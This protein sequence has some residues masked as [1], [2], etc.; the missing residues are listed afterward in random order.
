MPWAQYSVPHR[1]GMAVNV[2]LE[3]RPSEGINGADSHPWLHKEFKVSLRYLQ[4][5]LPERKGPGEEREGNGIPPP[6][7]TPSLLLFEV[8]SSP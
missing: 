6:P 7:R 8:F 3:R 1:L 4:A 5:H 2:Q